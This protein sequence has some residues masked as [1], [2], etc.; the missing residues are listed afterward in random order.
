MLPQS[1]VEFEDDMQTEVSPRI[2][3][4]LSAVHADLVAQ[5]VLSADADLET[6]AHH[7]SL[8]Q[9]GNFGCLHPWSRRTLVVAERGEVPA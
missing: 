8:R 7:L 4:I 2:Q 1:S 5:S 6:V 9:P 3:A